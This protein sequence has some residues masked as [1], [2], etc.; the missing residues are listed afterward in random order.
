MLDIYLVQCIL[1]NTAIIIFNKWDHHDALT[2]MNIKKGKFQIIFILL[3]QVYIH[4]LIY[5]FM[6]DKH[7]QTLSFKQ[8]PIEGLNLSLS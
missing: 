2:L 7:V 4:L 6:C 5:V 1:L 8:D 3:K